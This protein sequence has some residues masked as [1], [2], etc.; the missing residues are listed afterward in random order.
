MVMNV[1]L[2]NIPEALA[3]SQ[4]WWQAFHMHDSLLHL[5]KVKHKEIGEL[6]DMTK[7][8]FISRCFDFRHCNCRSFSVKELQNLKNNSSL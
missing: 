2:E 6:P 5:K 3:E 4:P 1:S 7:P 8:G